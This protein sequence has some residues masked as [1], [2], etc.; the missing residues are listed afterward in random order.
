MGQQIPFPQN[1]A[2]LVRLGKMASEQRKWPQAIAH[3]RAA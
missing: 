3:L 2:Q 1:F